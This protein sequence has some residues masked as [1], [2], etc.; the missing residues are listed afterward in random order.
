MKPLLSWARKRKQLPAAGEDESLPSGSEMS[1]LEHLEDLRWTLLKGFGAVFVATIVAVIFRDWISDEILLGPAQE[2]FFMYRVFGLEAKSLL[3]QNRTLTGQFFALVGIIVSVGVVLGFPVFMYFLWRFVEPGLYP[4]EKASLRFA[5]VFATV[6]FLI[7][8]AFGYLVIT[9][10]A[11]QF[12]NTFTITDQIVNDFDVT[13]YFSMLTW[14]AVGAGIL[15]ELPVVVYFLAK[16]GIATPE[17]LRS[18][19]KFALP[20]VLIAGALLTPPDPVSQVLVAAPL[21]LLYE[22]SILVARIAEKR[23]QA[24]LRKAWGDDEQQADSSP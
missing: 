10:I 4:S 21:F 14:W 20:G 1:F 2:D 11:L 6:F 8:V 16:L 15:F 9:P 13:R 17:R 24:A 23:R 22:G 18:S 12:F 5:A 19:R 7:G 3:L